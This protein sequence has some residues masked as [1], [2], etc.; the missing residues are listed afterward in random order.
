[1]DRAR[2]V[3]SR[4][5]PLGT[6][7]HYGSRLLLHHA[8]RVI[9]GIDEAEAGLREFT[10]GKRAIIRIAGLNSVIRALVPETKN[11]V[12]S[13]VKRFIIS[14]AQLSLDDTLTAGAISLQ[15][16]SLESAKPAR[17]RYGC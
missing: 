7:G 5:Q 3:Q 10:N 12:S 4:H 15:A 6:D 2:A 11:I 8:Q 1:M 14:S 9:K 17:L 16:V 13:R